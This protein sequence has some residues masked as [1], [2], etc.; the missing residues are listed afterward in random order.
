MYKSVRDTL[1]AFS[2][3]HL[4]NL[5]Y[6]IVERLRSKNNKISI[7]FKPDRIQKSKHV[8]KA[9]Q[10]FKKRK[11]WRI[12][13]VVLDR[14]VNPFVGALT[15]SIEGVDQISKLG[16]F[17]THHGFLE[18]ME[19]TETENNLEYKEG[20]PK[21][22]NMNRALEVEQ[23]ILSPYIFVPN[24]NK[25]IKKADGK[26]FSKN[27]KPAYMSLNVSR[28]IIESNK[29]SLI[30]LVLEKIIYD[31]IDK[32]IPG[33]KNEQMLDLYD[34]RVQKE[35]HLQDDVV[36]VAHINKLGQQAS[37]LIN[38][39]SNKTNMLGNN[40]N[41]GQSVNPSS[42]S[43]GISKVPE[44]LFVDNTLTV[45]ASANETSVNK[46]TNQLQD[47]TESSIKADQQPFKPTRPLKPTSVTNR[48]E[49]SA[50]QPTVAANSKETSAGIGLSQTSKSTKENLTSQ[51]N[52]Q[53][54][55]DTIVQNPKK[56][57]VKIVGPEIS[58]AETIAKTNATNGKNKSKLMV[59]DKKRNFNQ[60]QNINKTEKT[61]I[62]STNRDL[63]QT[64][65]VERKELDAS[66]N[67]ENKK[68]ASSTSANQ[69]CR[70]KPTQTTNSNIL[71][72]EHSAVP[73][74]QNVKNVGRRI[75]R[76]KQ[77]TSRINI[78]NKTSS[79]V[80]HHLKRKILKTKQLKAGLSKDLD[81]KEPK[82]VEQPAV[83]SVNSNVDR[84][85]GTEVTLQSSIKLNPH[86]TTSSRIVESNESNGLTLNNEEDKKPDIQQLVSSTACT[87]SVVPEDNMKTVFVS[88]NTTDDE[89]QF[90]ERKQ[91]V[92]NSI[93]SELI[94]LNMVLESENKRKPVVKENVK[95]MEKE[96][97]DKKKPVSKA[98]FLAEKAKLRPWRRRK[99]AIRSKNSKPKLDANVE[100]NMSEKLPKSTE[101][102]VLK[103]LQIQ[104]LNEN[105]MGVDL[106][107][108]N[109]FVNKTQSSNAKDETFESNLNTTKEKRSK[110][111]N[112]VYNSNEI[113]KN[114]LTSKNINNNTNEKHKLVQKARIKTREEIK[115]LEKSKAKPIN[116]NVNAMSQKHTNTNLK[117]EIKT[118]VRKPLDKKEF[119]K[120]NSPVKINENKNIRSST[121]NEQDEHKNDYSDDKQRSISIKKSIRKDSITNPINNKEM[122]KE[123]SLK[124][125]SKRGQELQQKTKT[126]PN[127][128]HLTITSNLKNKQTVTKSSEYP[129]KRETPVID[130]INNIQVTINNKLKP[131]NAKVTSAESHNRII[132]PRSPKSTESVRPPLNMPKNQKGQENLNNSN[133]K[134]STNTKKPSIPMKVLRAEL[135][136]TARDVSKTDKKAFINQ[137]G[138][139]NKKSVNETVFAVSSKSN[140]SNNHNQ[141]L[142]NL[143]KRK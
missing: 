93:K 45:T 59:N 1:Q 28:N 51:S 42:N 122:Y 107:S 135:K 121:K 38:V 53:K 133:Q 73:N 137:Q 83:V 49:T 16:D 10:V 140:K 87:K 117:E 13:D 94:N 80:K 118:N 50:F 78:S 64:V 62:S 125:N 86:I 120:L 69:N 100:S 128:N 7:S 77:I 29:S 97:G 40:I 106:E 74:I 98:S 44:M 55:K 92:G 9:S 110:N 75:N 141:I 123:T 138:F 90:I 57:S 56:T 66:P 116:T 41:T 82:T 52:K 24:E 43:K 85:E 15:P 6:S 115:F 127:I 60:E 22:F 31:K 134:A 129:K 130:K 103:N 96:N 79:F 46:V 81:I 88:F 71:N 61:E 136:T 36:Q 131:E 143:V 34:F 72:P 4:P 99:N 114:T 119:V 101:T 8:K 47:C 132:T 5:N 104:N 95:A 67:I 68:P 14:L 63:L 35:N 23:C 25:N 19:E 33:I 18:K 26:W 76:D 48:K 27:R 39:N 109:P 17:R 112:K 108:H 126:N 54:P 113:H 21:T 91:L 11:T 37:T 58:S 20:N 30:G 70:Q 139:V 89:A 65:G 2:R 105:D 32:L 142:Q 124:G 102:P 3:R 111:V 12:H 84:S